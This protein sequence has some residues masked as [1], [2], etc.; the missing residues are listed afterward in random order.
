M[1]RHAAAVCRRHSPSL[2][3]SKLLPKSYKRPTANLHPPS[4]LAP[5]SA[6]LRCCS[7]ADEVS[8]QEL[9]SKSVTVFRS[10][11]ATEETAG[12]GGVSTIVLRGATM[13]LLDDMERAIDDAG[14][15][16][17]VG[18]TGWRSVA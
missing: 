17:G 7:Y 3:W 13:N 2:C 15:C 14:A 1:A 6:R 4:L 16:G 9:S 12:A 11:S 18:R 8:V 5:I 10:D